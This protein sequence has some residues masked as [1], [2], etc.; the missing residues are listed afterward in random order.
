MK[1][2]VVRL[3]LTVVFLMAC[4]STSL[5]AIDTMPRPPYCPPDCTCN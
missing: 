4:G 5:L 1:K 3:T 2:N